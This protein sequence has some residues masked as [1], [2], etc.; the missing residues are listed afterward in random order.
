MKVKQPNSK[1]C[2][3]CGLENPIGLK[4]QF[5]ISGQGEVTAEY[6]VPEQYQGY[7]GIVHG[8]VVASMLDEVLGRAHMVGGNSD[9]S[10]FMYTARMTVR[11]RQHVPIGE[12]LR[13]IGCALK[14]RS[15]SATSKATIYN[16]EGEILAEA[17]G[18]LIDVPSDTLESTDLEAL[19]W[20]VYPDK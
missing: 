12:P 1:Q 11:Y 20:R 14:N 18:L 6:T 5:Y 3:V 19:G 15:N 17:E 13:I 4:M 9:N 8:G 2:F 7:P 16:S 10:R